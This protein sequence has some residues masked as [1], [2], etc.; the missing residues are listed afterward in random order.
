MA[1]VISL[2]LN[3]LNFDYVKSYIAMG[4]LPCFAKLLREHPLVETVSE[5]G[6][7]HLE[8]WIQW[9]TVYSGK[10]FAE[11]GVFR[12]GDIVDTS[13]RQIWEALEERGVS[14]GA[15]SPMNADNRCAHADFF[16][17]DPWTK[18]EVTG[19]ASIRKLAA[20]ISAGVN[21]NATG[22]GE[23][24]GAAQLGLRLLPFLLKYG[25]SSSLGSYLRIVGAARKYKWARA[26]LLDRFLA[27]VFLQ[28]R[29]QKGTQFASL[30]VNAG[31][32]IQ[33]HHMFES[34][35]YEGSQSNPDWYSS[36]KKDGQDPLLF[37]YEIYDTIVGDLLAL[38]DTRLMITTGLSQKA[39]P[40]TVYQYRFVDHAKSLEAL[41]VEGF[42]VVPRMSRDFLLKFDDRADAVAASTRL[43]A[44]RCMGEPLFIVEDRGNSLFVQ[45]GY[46]G[47]VEAF[48]TCEIDGKPFDFSADVALVSIENGIHRTIGYYVDTGMTLAQAPS[49]PIPLTTLYD[50]VLACFDEEKAPLIAAA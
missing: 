32:H 29:Q 30:F 23:G 36:A 35:V 40:N 6:Y 42:D 33:H 50:R 7:P 22:A 8:P 43:L 19:D 15:L 38:K 9:P 18:T 14:V 48:R 31:A 13:H 41:G 1:K 46:F 39:N 3:E 27:D 4:K 17:P 44:A 25:L 16:V 11:H 45:V 21:G 37:V 47:P 26:I 2:E 5:A 20:L 24:L 28:L 12:L 10:G 34:Q 49:G